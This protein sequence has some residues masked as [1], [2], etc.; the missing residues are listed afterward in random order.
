LEPNHKFFASGRFCEDS[1]FQGVARS[2]N[3]Q[4]VYEKMGVPLLSTGMVGTDE[5]GT[6]LIG[7]G[8]GSFVT[9][10]ETEG[11]FAVWHA[12]VGTNCQ[13]YPF[14]GKVVFGED[15]WPYVDFPEDEREERHCADQERGVQY[16]Q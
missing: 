7:P 11:L 9:H 14:V 2:R 3:L 8:H 1:Y 5:R 10:Q 15:D 6:Q 16:R 13:R 12:S 4:G